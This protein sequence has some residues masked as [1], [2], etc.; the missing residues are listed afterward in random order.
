MTLS[1]A[2]LGT[3][4]VAA[5]EQGLAFVGWGLDVCVTALLMV[6]GKPPV[7]NLILALIN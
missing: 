4:C 5:P 3:C 1:H 2:P 7:P 6:I